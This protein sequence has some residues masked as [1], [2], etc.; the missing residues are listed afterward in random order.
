MKNSLQI[1]WMVLLVMTGCMKSNEEAELSLNPLPAVSASGAA[2]K[3]SKTLIG[4]PADVTKTTHGGTCLMGGGTDVD[5]AFKWMITLS[6]GGDFVVITTSTS[7][8]YNSYVYNLG[9][10]NSVETIRIS[11]TTDANSTT[12]ET[13]I[14]N[15]EALFITGGDQAEYVKLWKNTKVEDAINYLINVKKVPVGGTS[16]GCAILGS[17]YF[18]A[19][20]GTVTSAD[21]MSDP[22]NSLVSLGHNDF[23]TNAWLKNTITDQ[24]FTQRGREGRLVT[25]MARM[26]KDLTI[27]PRGIASDEQTAV[28]VDE[29]GIAKVYG[30]NNAFFLQKT[31]LGPE[32]CVAG[33]PL[34]WNRSQMAV[35]VYRISGSTSGNGTFDLKNFTTASG[36]T[37]MYYYVDNGVFHAN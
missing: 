4:D 6:G 27:D 23:L 8:A 21:A 35:K 12:V 29:A 20:N 3:Q 7:V 22:Y 37:W 13:K 31:N 19:L 18:A 28:C 14:R 10:V 17:S 1:F 32:T 36:D 2:V 26:N 5:A 25:F 16:A 24:H 33:M 9:S 34:T 11:K 30:V 15:A